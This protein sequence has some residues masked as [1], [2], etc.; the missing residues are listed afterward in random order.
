MTP[1][2]GTGYGASIYWRSVMKDL[3]NESGEACP[4]WTKDEPKIDFNGDHGLEIKVTCQAKDCDKTFPQTEKRLVGRFM[5]FY[6][7]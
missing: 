6:K 5:E 7:V 2:D 3:A 1:Y 4:C